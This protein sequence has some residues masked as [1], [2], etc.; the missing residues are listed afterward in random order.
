MKRYFTKSTSVYM[1]LTLALIGFVFLSNGWAENKI[2]MSDMLLKVEYPGFFTNLGSTGFSIYDWGEEKLKFFNWNFQLIKQM[3]LTRGEGPD[4]VMQ[5]VLAAYLVKDKIFLIGLMEN[6]IKIF[7]QDGKFIKSIPLEIMAREMVYQ[8]EQDKLYIFN[9]QISAGANSFLLAKI[10][11][12]NSNKP[13]ENIMVN[14]QLESSKFLEGNALMI[15]L[16]SIFAMGNNK[17]IYMV[18]SSANALYEFE[19]NG[20]FLRKVKLPY[21]ERKVIRTTK[22]NG[23]DYTLISDLDFYT[24]MKVIQD[25]L[26]ICFLRQIKKDKKTGADIFQTHILKFSG[27]KFPEKIV[28]GNNFIIGE[29]QGN[30]YLFNIDDYQATIINLGKW[31]DKK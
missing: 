21:N 5:N 9:L 28:E 18:T 8:P 14:S 2:D 29:N 4:Q 25:T 27:D 10:I 12:P 7:G 23:E 1:G 11:D 17:M 20:K 26:Y 30:L 3:P 22:R 6:K 31:K 15:G 24:N 16:S 13:G 19:G